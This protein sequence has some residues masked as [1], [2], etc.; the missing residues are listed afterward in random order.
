MGGRTVAGHGPELQRH[1]GLLHAT[2]LNVS[3]IVG[4]GV[5]ATIPLMLGK[6]PGPYALL[7]WVVAGALMIVDGLIWSELGAAFPGSGG[8]YLY[9]LECYGRDRFGRVMAFLFIWQFLISGPLEIASGLIALAQFANAF[10]PAYA[11][12]IERWTWKYTFSQK[13]NLALIVNP[14]K[15]IAIGA[16]LLL[17]LLLYRG[18]AS[19]KWLTV[20]VWVGVLALIAW[21]LIEGWCR[22]SPEI[23]FDFDGA[24]WPNDYGQAL[25]GAMV[26]AMYSYLGYYN[27]CYIGAEVHDPGRTIPR[28]ILISALLVCVLFIGLHVAMLGVVPWQ[29][30]PKPKEAPLEG[31]VEQLTDDAEP[32][33]V[34]QDAKKPSLDDYSLAADFMRRA[35]GEWAVIVVTFLLIWSCFGSAFAGLLGYSRIPYAAA[36]NGHFFAAFSQVH[37]HHRI[38]HVALLFV[39]ALT[40]FWT[41]FNLQSVIDALIVTRILEQFI[42]QIVAVMLLRNLQPN[43]PRPYQMFLYPLPCGLALLGWLFMYLS[44][45]WLYIALG[46]GTLL[47]GGLVFLVWTWRTRQWPFAEVADA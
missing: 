36:Q 18:M 7:G 17:V 19:L 12:F 14:G 43:R 38:P 10:D 24:L 9:L 4:A 26:L 33:P 3:M 11:E 44:A 6:L 47:A 27:V 29:E 37:P 41:F 28:S 45:N 42:G 23:A 46:I 31:T 32:A 35:H 40:L 8:S 22:F 16:G 15:A 1:F 2:A 30:V 34:E 5:F 25:G 20:T 13:A 39:G 21:I